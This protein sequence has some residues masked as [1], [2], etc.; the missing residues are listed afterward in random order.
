MQRQAQPK[1]GQDTGEVRSARRRGRLVWHAGLLLVLAALLLGCA[2]QPEPQADAA[3]PLRVVA[4]MSIVADLTEQVGG[5]LVHI[6][7]IVPVG[8]DPHT[9]E[10]RP[11]DAQLVEDADLLVSNGAGLEE[12]WLQDMLARSDAIHAELAGDLEPRIFTEG[13]DVGEPDPHMWNDPILVRDGYLPVL[14]TALKE[15]LPDEQAD[16]VAERA[17]TYTEELS[18]LDADLAAAVDTIPD[19][20]RKLVTTHD[21]FTYFGARYGV[22]VSGTLY[23][24]STEVE[25]SAAEV[26]ELIEVIRDEQVPAVFIE[27]LTDPALMERVASE[28][29]VALGRELLGD[30]VGEEPGT[31]TYVGMMRANVGAIVEGLGGSAT[32]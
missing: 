2:E 14:V 6:D 17:E 4:T 31:D 15:A 11:G 13:E 28:A 29:G 25:P 18:T 24:V 5:D 21:A 32:L 10:P 3:A 8:A 22:T 30:S 19:G 12:R 1:R 16:D 27:T 26:S 7:V 20:N 9:Y 23:G